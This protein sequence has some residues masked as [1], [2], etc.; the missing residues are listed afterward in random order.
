[1][2]CQLLQPNSKCGGTG[3][4]SLYFK[5]NVPKLFGPASDTWSAGPALPR[6]SCFHAAV[7]D[8]VVHVTS[9]VGT[10]IYDGTAWE[11]VGGG[12]LDGAACGLIL[13]G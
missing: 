8:G 9:P 11:E 4:C 12:S 10:W 2:P 1:M 5:L 13:R 7:L 3:L 6:A